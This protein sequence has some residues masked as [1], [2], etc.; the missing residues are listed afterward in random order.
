MNA[1]SLLT[2]QYQNIATDANNLA[3]IRG[4]GHY[5]A[6]HPLSSNWGIG[7]GSFHKTFSSLMP[8]SS[9]D[10][11]I[12][13]NA[14]VGDH[15]NTNWN[16]DG[17]SFKTEHFTSLGNEGL[18]GDAYTNFILKSL[19]LTPEE[20]ALVFFSTDNV[21]YLQQRI[22]D[23]VEKIRGLKVSRQSDNELLIIMRAKYMYA[24][25][26]FLPRSSDPYGAHQRGGAPC[27]L[28]NR[29][30]RLNQSVLQECIKQVLGGIDEYITYYKDA[31]SLPVPLEHPRLASMKGSRV[32]EY[33]TG[34]YS[35]NSRGADSFNMRYTM[36][37]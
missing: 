23:D 20:L 5:S 25:S 19:K 22:I 4:S 24:L 37:N 8:I 26:G 13:S 14:P 35:G 28:R 27:S 16:L 7:D 9:K 33:N 17:P 36:V 3:R 18:R 31:S 32:L 12:S 21:N 1:S 34:L 15:R 6:T 10:Y 11:N 29:L 2:A 30:T